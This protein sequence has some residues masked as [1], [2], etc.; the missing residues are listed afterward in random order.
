MIDIIKN[1]C[2]TVHS[3]DDTD[4]I[5]IAGLAIAG[6]YVF[7]KITKPILAPDPWDA[8]QANHA[9]EQ[10]GGTI[11]NSQLGS[12]YQIP[13]GSIKL[14][15]GWTPNFAQRVLIGVDSFIPGDWLTRKVLGV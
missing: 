10:A 14:D 15:S 11:T 3:M 6:I 8:E 7:N 1:L 2:I 4:L 5:I 12:F 9:I 13:G